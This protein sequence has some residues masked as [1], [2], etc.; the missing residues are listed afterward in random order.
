MIQ[1]F[2][3]MI[4]KD[5]ENENETKKVSV[6]LRLNAIIMCIYFLCLLGIFAIGG[7]SRQLFMLVPCL[8]VYALAFYTTYL[9]ETKFAALFSVSITVAW[10]V[11]FTRQFGWDC[12]IQHFIFVL[13]VLDFTI[14]YSRQ[15]RKIVMSALACLLR[16]LLYAYTSHHE[17]NHVMGHEMCAIYQTA[18]T[19]FVF[20]CI[21]GI[22]LLFTKDSQEMEHKLV[23]YNE[24]LHKLASLD[25]LTGLLNRRS[26]REFLE[27]RIKAYNDGSIGNLSIAIGDIDFFKKIN[28]TYGHEC[29]D[30][31]L[32]ELS[33]LFKEHLGSK[34]TI[35][36]W[37]GEEFLFAFHHMNGDEALMALNELNRKL[38]KLEI[39]YKGEN[40]K[41][42][43]TFGL[44]EFDFEHGIDYSVNDVDKKLYRGK[45]TG[46]DRTIY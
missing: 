19:I 34:G 24:K 17:P 29:G 28:D 43:M 38:K 45:E 16:L 14:S 18:N 25:P 7:E 31:V 20:I 8:G 23:Q 1:K 6:I 27:K 2:I 39:P 21:T 42:T 41:V 10:I 35:S 22:L 15:R 33:A 3:T 40:V 30:L 9:N 12:G 32:K 5:V 11:V 4:F 46:R 44:S 36:R 26:M 37:G 13:L